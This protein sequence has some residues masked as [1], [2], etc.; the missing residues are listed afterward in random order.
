MSMPTD[1][2]KALSMGTQVIVAT[3]STVLMEQFEPQEIIL[4]DR[5]GPLSTFKR[6]DTRNLG[7]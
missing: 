2:I 6:L 5:D 3:Q 4:M 7:Y 1:L